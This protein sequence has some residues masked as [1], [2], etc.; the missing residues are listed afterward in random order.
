MI[1]V[2]Y[3][4]LSMLRV[5][6]TAAQLFI[7]FMITKTTA[8]GQDMR[9]MCSLRVYI[10]LLICSLSFDKFVIAFSSSRN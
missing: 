1:G 8:V 4:R 7:E 3:L 5:G 6:L 9:T 2:A 10:A